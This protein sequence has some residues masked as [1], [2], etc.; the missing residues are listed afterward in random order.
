[1]KLSAKERIG[2]RAMVEFARRHG[3]G[4]TP[5]REISR[6]EDLPLPY[7]EHVVGEL[8][9]S[10]LL[11]SVRGIHGGYV[12]GKEPSSIS[13][14]DVFRAVEGALVPLDCLGADSTVCSREQVCAARNVWQTISERLS[15]TLDNTSLSDLLL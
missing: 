11:Q 2:L 1:M 8:R 6:I 9:R 7:L 5:L 10:G 12:L 14:G 13:V 4:P 3:Q 15:E